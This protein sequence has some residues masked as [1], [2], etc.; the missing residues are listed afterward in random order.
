MLE[1]GDKRHFAFR[2]GDRTFFISD[3]FLIT[4]QKPYTIDR[5]CSEMILNQFQVPEI[6]GHYW[7]IIK[8]D[9]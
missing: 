7:E 3:F 9:L 4:F 2:Y 1:L 8:L 6:S 5:K